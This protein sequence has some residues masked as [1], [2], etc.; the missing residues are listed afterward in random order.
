MGEGLGDIDLVNPDNYVEHVPFAWFDHLRAEHPVV[1]HPEPAPNRGFWAV[2]RYDDLTAVHMDWETFSSELGAVA[3]EE[4]DEEQLEVRRSMLETDPPRHTELRKI[5]S[6]R[7]SA[8]GVGTY[9]DW[10]RD[11]ARDVL[12]RAL[13]MGA[14]DFVSEI[15]RPPDPLPVLDLH[16]AAGRRPEADRVG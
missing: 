14:F 3:L 9:E 6:K 2:T 7:F 1:W 16:G 10:I 12:D 13:P 11:V 5:C 8:R 4:L 15:S